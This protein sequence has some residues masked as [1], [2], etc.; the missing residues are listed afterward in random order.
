MDLQ[1]VFELTLIPGRK[2]NRDQK[3]FRM[4]SYTAFDWFNNYWG[5]REGFGT[6][7]KPE[8]FVGANGKKTCF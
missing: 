1:S 3:D 4:Q 2:T 6:K 5:E 8:G 7:R